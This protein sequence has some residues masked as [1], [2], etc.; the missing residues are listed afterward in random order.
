[1]ESTSSRETLVANDEEPFAALSRPVRHFASIRAEMN[2]EYFIKLGTLLAI[3]N[4]K[5]LAA[6]FCTISQLLTIRAE[7]WPVNM[8]KARFRTAKLPI[9]DELFVGQFGFIDQS[10]TVTAKGGVPPN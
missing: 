7:N 2:T 4:D 10:A 1:I 9:Y 3:Y 6:V 5:H 8:V